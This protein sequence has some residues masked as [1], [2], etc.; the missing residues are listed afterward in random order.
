MARVPG[1]WANWW[2]RSKPSRAESHPA[3]T[4]CGRCACARSRASPHADA[5]MTSKPASRSVNAYS[6]RTAPCPSAIS[7]NPRPAVS[8]WPPRDVCPLL[9]RS[10]VRG[11][12][13][14]VALLPVMEREVLGQHLPYRT[15][16]FVRHRRTG[17]E[18]Q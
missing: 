13:R 11:L 15:V 9:L 4:A 1:W 7:T 5:S 16:S 17:I 6:E 3:S 14:L 2:A 12:G 10:D 18:N 8:R